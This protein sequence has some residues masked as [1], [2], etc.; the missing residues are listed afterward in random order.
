MADPAFDFAATAPGFDDP[1]TAAQKMFR[2]A[3]EAMA[4]PGRIVEAAGDLLPKNQSGLSDAMAALALTL[5][6]FETPVWLDRSLAPARGFLRFHCGAPM[7]A[8][9]DASRFAF[10]A[11]PAALPDLDEFDLGSPE[12]PDRSTTLILE[13][14][15]LAEGPGLALRGPGIEAVTGLR[16]TGLA[17]GFWHQRQALL[18]RFPLGLDLFLTSGR[19]LAALPRTT[20]MEM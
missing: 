6:D 10:A 9:P 13:V 2:L 18:P 11:D 7:V 3:L 19:R 4:H 5:L 20:I 17:P 15:A 12:Y 16:V 1:V 14:A 8:T